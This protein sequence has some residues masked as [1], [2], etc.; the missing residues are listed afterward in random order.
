MRIA[1][2]IPRSCRDTSTVI[3]LPANLQGAGKFSPEAVSVDSAAFHPRISPGS[4]PPPQLL[5]STCVPS[6]GRRWHWPLGWRHTDMPARSGGSRRSLRSCVRLASC[7]EAA[8]GTSSV[9]VPC[10]THC[11]T[12]GCWPRRLFPGPLSPPE[13][14][15]RL[16]QDSKPSCLT[17]VPLP[18]AS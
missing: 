1:Q 11:H 15:L 6:R 16:G 18:Q 13:V 2:L 7:P 14:P 12:P 10:T 9:K 8:P 3:F 17:S 5:P 4:V